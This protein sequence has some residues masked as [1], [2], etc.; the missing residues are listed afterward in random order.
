MRAALLSHLAIF[1]QRK[2]P[3]KWQIEKEQTKELILKYL[4]E[5]HRQP[6]KSTFHQR[7]CEEVQDYNEN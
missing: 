3:K 5:Q 4:E 1:K 7:L 6:K 2:E